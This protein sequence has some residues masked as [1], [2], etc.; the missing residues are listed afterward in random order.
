[1][2]NG[3]LQVKYSDGIASLEID[4]HIQEITREDLF[5]VY[6]K[7]KRS[8]PI[9]LPLKEFVYRECED[10]GCNF[11][12][13]VHEKQHFCPLCYHIMDDLEKD[14][15][16]GFDIRF[17]KWQKELKMVEGII[18]GNIQEF[19]T[20]TNEERR[21]ERTHDELLDDVLGEEVIVDE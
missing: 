6:K 11:M 18:N 3:I 19:I 2:D 17:Q 5:E 14:I 12:G 20:K 1:M 21:T 9:Q 15:N 4:Q 16:E 8:K 13:V 10:G 7:I